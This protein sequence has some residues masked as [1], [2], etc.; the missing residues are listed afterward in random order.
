MKEII[1]FNTYDYWS[2]MG[3]KNGFSK[4]SQYHP[5]SCIGKSSQRLTAHAALCARFCKST[6]KEQEQQRRNL[7][8]K[9]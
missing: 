1:T 9:A 5:N 2:V 3:R 6:W 7:G 8:L 4:G